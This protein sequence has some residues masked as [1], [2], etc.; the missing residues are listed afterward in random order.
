VDPRFGY[1]AVV[2]S[3]V[4]GEVYLPSADLAPYLDVLDVAFCF[5]LLQADWTAPALRRAITAATA[6][7]GPTGRVAWV[8][9]NHDFARLP[10]RVGPANVRAAALLTL[11]LPGV[12]FIFQGDEIGMAD[13]PGIDPPIDRYGRDRH[14]HPMCWDASLPH[15]GFTDGRPWLPAVVDVPGGGVAQQ[16]SDPDS[17]LAFY[18]NVIAARR[19]MGA[20][21]G[22]ID[23][24]TGVLAYRRGH[25]HAVVLNLGDGPRSLPV[26]GTVVC[27]THAARHPAG[28]P[29]STSIGPGEGVVVL[30]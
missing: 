6:R 22:F 25:E 21:I 8:L 26:L 9:S 2:D 14:R 17:I 29:A 27:A 20:G 11:T 28:Q 24:E 7:D 18:R 13:G 1:L 30:T 23:A 12:A 3:L 19:T 10:D 4:A 15:G 5:E 16:E